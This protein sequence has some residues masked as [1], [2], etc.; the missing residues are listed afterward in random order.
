[1]RRIPDEIQEFFNVKRNN[2]LLIKGKPGSGKT[3]FSL[4]CLINLAEKGCGFYFSTRV[5]PETVFTQYPQICEQ[6]PPQ[7]IIDATS[8]FSIRSSNVHEAI[9]YS[10]VP[11][12]LR[13][14]Y[15]KVDKI[16]GKGTPI[17]VIDSIDAICETLDISDSKFMHIFADF[18]RKSGSKAI[19]VTEQSKSTKLDY[20]AD[21]V[22][23]LTYDM[24]EGRIYRE[25]HI[26]KLR[27][28]KIKNPII[29][30]TLIDGRFTLTQY[31]FH[32]TKDV[33]SKGQ[34]YFKII[35]EIKLPPGL[36]STGSL[37]LDKI[38]GYVRGGN[39]VLYE[40]EPYVPTITIIGLMTLH[41][42]GFISRGC[43]VIQIPPN[44][45]HGEF[46]FKFFKTVLGDEIKNIKLLIPEAC[47]VN[48]FSKKFLEELNE[49]NKNGNLSVIIFSIDALE[50]AFGRDGA[51]RIGAKI[52][53]E[54]R[55]NND[56]IIAFGH[57]SSKT[58]VLFRDMA[59]KVVRIFYKHGYVFI[60]GVRPK[61]PIY[62]VYYNPDSQYVDISLLEIV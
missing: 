58:R 48:S 6:V 44:Y 40:L 15:A 46:V 11:E 12:F 34:N 41:S 49:I 39:L 13:A 16:Q 59:E 52:V 22:I 47:S 43:K 51:F 21:G 57:E 9:Q 1:M 33:L 3:I 4:E 14:L 8:T 31:V 29:P 55:K 28:V 25:M 32:T 10:T 45:S 62:N 35:S 36:Y 50:S 20:L 19:I 38:I 24:I 2:I 53:A 5:D 30:F 42:I 61:T 27:S 56:V 17:I 54:G 60:Y 26:E 7:N 23:Y 37:S 18:T